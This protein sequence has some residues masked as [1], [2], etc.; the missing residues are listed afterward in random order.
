[1]TLD[2]DALARAVVAGAWVWL[3]AFAALALRPRGNRVKHVR[4]AFRRWSREVTLCRAARR[5]ARTARREAAVYNDRYTG[6]L[7]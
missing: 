6:A 4:R 1:M 2:I 5:E 7:G 3:V